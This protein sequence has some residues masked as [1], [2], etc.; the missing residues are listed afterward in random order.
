MQSSRIKKNSGRSGIDIE[1]TEH[2]FWFC[3]CRLYRHMIHLFCVGCGLLVTILSLWG[4]LV[5][6]L[7][8]I[9]RQVTLFT[10][11]KTLVWSARGTNLHGSVV[12]RSL[13]W[14]LLTTLLLRTMIAILLLV[15][16]TLL[17]RVALRVLTTIPLIGWSLVPL[18]ET[19][20]RIG[21]RTSIASRGLSLKPP[22]LGLHLFTLIINNNSAFHQCLEIGVCIRHKLELQSIIQTL[23]KAVLFIRII[24]H[25]IRSI[26]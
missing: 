4:L 14:C 8:A 23:E 15:W 2:D 7:R 20:L 12:R 9:I 6:L 25:L 16:W 18:L 22:L 13:S 17:V 21:A 1:H 11:M 26:T 19:L 24:S 10:T 5:Q 3:T